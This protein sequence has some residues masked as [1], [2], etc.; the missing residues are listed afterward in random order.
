[1][2][3][4]TNLKEELKEFR[5][6]RLRKLILELTAIR[7]KKVSRRLLF[8]FI[9]IYIIS[10][11]CLLKSHIFDDAFYL[12]LLFPL[13]ISLLLITI[14]YIIGFFSFFKNQHEAMIIEKLKTELATLTDESESDIDML[15]EIGKIRDF[16]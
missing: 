6:E 1:M 16:F 3:D 11:F 12:T 8:V 10:F 15:L 7:E 2:N 9:A 4:N 5:I 13:I 14:S